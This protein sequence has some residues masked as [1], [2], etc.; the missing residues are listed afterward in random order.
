MEAADVIIS[1]RSADQLDC[2]DKRIMSEKQFVIN[3]D[4]DTFYEYESELQRDVSCY[5][6][7]PKTMAAFI[8]NCKKAGI[9]MDNIATITIRNQ[10]DGNGDSAMFFSDE[11]FK[12]YKQRYE[13]AETDEE[14]NEIVDEL[15]EYVRSEP[16]VDV[17]DNE[18]ANDGEWPISYL[19]TDDDL[20]SYMLEY[21]NGK[22]KRDYYMATLTD[23]YTID[24]KE[25][26]LE[27][28][29]SMV[30]GSD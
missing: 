4:E 29:E 11:V 2:H 15:V 21:L 25:N 17:A 10:K 18:G 20:R 7:T 19:G 22:R 24:L 27:E 30:F 3:Y 5:E 26:S 13:Q 12:E 1:N 23:E 14:K 16:E 6:A 28:K 8:E 9:T